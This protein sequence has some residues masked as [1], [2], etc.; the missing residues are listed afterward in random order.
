MKQ[1][2]LINKW[3]L[4]LI[5]ILLIF[6]IFSWIAKQSAVTPAIIPTSRPTTSPTLVT[7]E[8]SV[9]SK[10]QSATPTPNTVLTS[11]SQEWAYFGN[12]LWQN[13]F[14]PVNHMTPTS[15]SR[16]ALVYD[17]ELSDSKGGNEA[18]PLM[19]NGI[20]YMTT[21]KAHVIALDAITGKILWTFIPEIHTTKG[22]P[23]INRGVALGSDK[24][25]VLTPDNQLIAIRKIDGVQLFSVIVADAKL[26]YFETM[27][28]LYADG[29]VFVGSSGGDEGVRGFVSA[30]DAET[31]SK[32]WQFYTV[33]EH[34]QDWMPMDGDHGG[35][36]VWTTPAYDPDSKLLYFGTGN[37]SPDYFGEARQGPNP[38]TDSVV[39]LDVITG[40]IV[41]YQQEVPHDLW[42]YDVASPPMLFK[43]QSNL[44][45]GEAGKDG[46]W[47]EWD[48]KTGKPFTTPTAFVK[49]DRKPPTA[50]GTKVWPG[51][52]GGANYGP[53]AYSPLNKQVYISGIN[54]PEILYAKK[55]E[56]HVG[57]LD[58][59]TGQNP[60]PA[61]EWSGTITAIDTETG[62]QR[63][64]IETATPPIGGVTVNA[65][66][67]VVF[68]Q[69][70]QTGTLEAVSAKTG[71][72]LWSTETGAPIG[73]APII[74]Q[75]NGHSYLTVVTGGAKSLLSL[76]PYNGPAHVL[77]FRID[78]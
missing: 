64:Q 68:G 44:V 16:A 49:Q 42:D 62:K 73:S 45:V 53:S 74:Y 71:E 23:Q 33:P 70:N 26:G 21:G 19:E 69:A 14:S 17:R 2:K 50:E 9:S 24:I 8:E 37:P 39:A 34:G 56:H 30:Y 35:G 13:R 46:F 4:T 7:P 20:L 36:A 72:L 41:W 25:Y 47:Y 28:P 32:L 67:I 27:A 52:A 61:G 40:K 77:T 12:N 54:G 1:N 15:I 60:A 11:Y 51:P 3:T 43:V 78:D 75:L 63:W 76:Y 18:Y 65:G 66:N 5:I 31:G 29:R 48:A 55:K 57:E 6:G 58:F 59:G 10:V 22:M 38:Y